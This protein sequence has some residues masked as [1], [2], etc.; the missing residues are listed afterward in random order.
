M[1][2]TG[3]TACARPGCRRND[4]PEPS[5]KGLG[6]AKTRR[7]VRPVERCCSA[8]RI[9][10]ACVVVFTGSRSAAKSESHQW[11]AYQRFYTARVRNRRVVAALA[12]EQVPLFPAG[13]AATPKTRPTLK[14]FPPAVPSRRSLIRAARDRLHSNCQDNERSP[15]D[16]GKAVCHLADGKPR[17]GVRLAIGFRSVADADRAI[18]IGPRVPGT[19]HGERIV[20]STKRKD[21]DEFP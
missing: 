18:G 3:S 12:R 21:P 13:I 4:A 5:A 16:R 6:C 1:P 20:G 14:W 17:R 15:A 19:R 9:Y 11:S 10:A 2:S 8:V 7:R